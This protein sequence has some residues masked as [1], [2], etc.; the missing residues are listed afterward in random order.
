MNF[1]LKQQKISKRDRVV[2]TWY[3]GLGYI[4][5]VISWCLSMD[6]GA[7]KQG[8]F[9]VFVFVLICFVCFVCLFVFV[10]VFVFV[11]SFF[12]FFLFLCSSIQGIAQIVTITGLLTILPLTVSNPGYDS[13][14]RLIWLHE[15]CWCLSNLLI[16]YMKENRI[17]LVLFLKYF[18][19]NFASKSEIMHRRPRTVSNRNQTPGINHP[20]VRNAV[21]WRHKSNYPPKRRSAEQKVKSS[22]QLLFSI[23]E[24][25]ERCEATGI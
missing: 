25:M 11:F 20:V 17:I 3:E 14:E 9:F 12:L 18:I 23:V 24:L 4:L 21:Q 5:L 8:F 15:I 2:T 22:H 7:E 19:S 6:S 16:K 10:F 13:Q 1:M